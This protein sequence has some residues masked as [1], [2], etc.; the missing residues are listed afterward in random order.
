MQLEYYAVLI[1]HF[2]ILKALLS[3]MQSYSTAMGWGQSKCSLGKRVE[4]SGGICLD[5]KLLWIFYNQM[6]SSLEFS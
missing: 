4:L 2:R 1:D 3:N 5:I 6:C